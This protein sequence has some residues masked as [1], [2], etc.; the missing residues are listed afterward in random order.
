MRYCVQATK[1]QLH[2]WRI[3]EIWL[4]NIFYGKLMGFYRG[5]LNVSSDVIRLLFDFKIGR[6]RDVKY[7]SLFYSK[8]CSGGT[9]GKESACQCR[10]H[11]SHK[12]NPCIGKIP[13]RRKWQPTPIFLPG[14][15]LG[16]RS[17]AGC[18]PWGHK[19]LDM[20][21]HA[22]TLTLFRLHLK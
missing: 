17:L 9:S 18:S 16:Q 8:L 22:H 3:G 15:F 20:T 14:K 2:K 7:L 12:F 19:D 13:R 4:G 10:R 6:I 5:Q 21:E 11:K 1:K